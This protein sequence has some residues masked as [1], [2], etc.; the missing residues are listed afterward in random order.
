MT[1][2]Q[3]AY[4]GLAERCGCPR[5]L[6]RRQ[7]RT[8]VRPLDLRR[9]ARDLRLLRIP[10]AGALNWRAYV[11]GFCDRAAGGRCGDLRPVAAALRRLRGRP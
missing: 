5:W 4:L 10:W 9:T 6:R 8:A 1:S 3:L 7:G 2:E 11:G